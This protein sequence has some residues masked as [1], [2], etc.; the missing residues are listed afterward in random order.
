[1]FRI[2]NIVP[3]IEVRSLH[4]EGRKSVIK[5]SFLSVIIGRSGSS[6]VGCQSQG[7]S[8]FRLSKTWSCVRSPSSGSRV[9]WSKESVTHARTTMCRRFVL[10]GKKQKQG[11]TQQRPPMEWWPYLYS[12][13]K[14]PNQFLVTLVVFLVLNDMRQLWILKVFGDPAAV[15]DDH[16]GDTSQS[17]RTISVELNKGRSLD[18]SQ[19]TH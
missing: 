11:P 8:L 19:R 5:V 3:S 17:V 15:L 14:S 10:R 6:F 9:S 2:V 13:R 7:V 4:C 1:M 18:R 12:L 16:G